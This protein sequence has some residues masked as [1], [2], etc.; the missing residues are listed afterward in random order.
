M[1]SW[2]LKGDS[3]SF[4][5]SAPRTI[6]LRNREGTPNHVEIFDITNIPSP[7]SAISETT[8]LCDIFGDDRDSP[9][10][11]GSPAS[12]AFAPPPREVDRAAAASPLV[13]DSSGS[14]H[15]A[16][17]SSEGEE[18]FE[19]PKERLRSPLL[20]TGNS[21][22]QDS[23]GHNQTSEHSGLSE[24][25]PKLESA[26]SPPLPLLS[27]EGASLEVLNRVP[28]S[29]TPSPRPNSSET[30]EGTEYRGITSSP[31]S[32]LSSNRTSSP[33][34]SPQPSNL[35]ASSSSIESQ[36]TPSLLES[37]GSPKRSSS[38]SGSRKSSPSSE[39]RP[40]SSD[41]LR[42]LTPPTFNP[43]VVFSSNST[44]RSSVDIHRQSGER[45][46]TPESRDYSYSPDTQDCSPFSEL[47]GR[48][49]V[50]DLFSRG[51]T[52]DIDDSPCTSTPDI[53]GSPCTP[54]LISCT[55]LAGGDTPENRGS[56]LSAEAKSAAS[57][58]LPRYTPPSPVS[59]IPRTPE[60]RG[61][62][63]SPAVRFTPSPALSLGVPH[64]APTPDSLSLAHSPVPYSPP[65][66]K[67]NSDCCPKESD[68]TSS[69]PEIRVT[70]SSPE[71]R[72]REKSLEE[73]LA[74]NSAD[75]SQ[76]SR[77]TT[78]S[79]HITGPC[80]SVVQPEDG[81][82]ATY[83]EIAHLSTSEPICRNPQSPEPQCKSPVRQID[84][85]TAQ[86]ETTVTIVT[87][88]QYYKYSDPEPDNTD[89]TEL[90]QPR[91][92]SLSPEPRSYTPSPELRNQGPSTETSP[93]SPIPE[94]R[95]LFPVPEKR[96]DTLPPE[97]RFLAPSPGKI[98]YT[99]SPEPIHFETQPSPSPESRSQ[100]VELYN[101]SPKPSDILPSP[102]RR[103]LAPSPQQRNLRLSSE[104]IQIPPSPKPR[105]L[106][107][108]PEKRQKT[109][110]PQ[111]RNLAPSP[112][113]RH[114]TPSPQQRDLTSST[115]KR[116]LTPSPQLRDPTQSPEKSLFN[117]SPQ[118]RYPTPSPVNIHYTSSPEPINFAPSPLDIHYSPMCE[119]KDNVFSPKEKGQTQSP[120]LIHNPSSPV[121][122]L[123]VPSP[124]PTFRNLSPERRY[125]SISP[126]SRRHITLPDPPRPT[127][128]PESR[129]NQSL[130]DISYQN[131]S[132]D[133]RYHTPSPRDL[134]S[135]HKSSLPSPVPGAE[136]L[137]PSPQPSHISHPP[138]SRHQSP[139][140]TDSNALSKSPEYSIGQPSPTGSPLHNVDPFSTPELSLFP[141]DTPEMGESSL[142]DISN[143][144]Q[145][146]VDR[147]SAP[148]ETN[149][150]V[151]PPGERK[152]SRTP[153]QHCEP[154]E[155]TPE[156]T[157]P[158]S[159]QSNYFNQK[160]DHHWNPPIE[161]QSP[162]HGLPVSTVDGQPDT[163]L[164]R[165]TA[166]ISPVRQGKHPKPKFPINSRRSDRN[167][168]NKNSETSRTPDYPRKQPTTKVVILSREEPAEDTARH[169]SKRRTPSP[170]ITRFTPVHIIAPEKPY[171]LW[172]N[173]CRSPPQAAASTLT[174]NSKN[175]MAKWGSPGETCRNSNNQDDWLGQN[176]HMG[177]VGEISLEAERKRG[178]DPG[179]EQHKCTRKEM[180]SERKREERLQE[181][182]EGTKA[183][184]SYRGQQ[185]ELSFSARNRK[186]PE[187][188]SAASTGKQTSKGMPTAHSYS[189]R[190][191]ATRQPQQQQRRGGPARRLQPSVAQNMN[192]ATG[193]VSKNRPRQSS[194]SSIGSEQDEA[195]SEVK[196][197][198]DGAFHSLSSP[199]ID[200]LD[201]YNSSH[202]SSTNISQPSTQESPAGASASLL[203]YADFR[204]S[205]Q[206]LD[207]EDFPFQPTTYYSDGLDPAK[208]Y[209]MGSFECVDVAV[210]RE[211]PRKARRGVPKR[212]IQLKRKN[213]LESRQDESSE[214]GSPVVPGM[215]DS[216]SFRGSLKETLLR[217]HSTPVTMHEPY[218]C[219]LSTDIQEY[220]NKTFKLQKSTSLDETHPK[221]K[222]ATCLIKSVLSKKMQGV[223]SS[224]EEKTSSSVQV[225]DTLEKS[226]EKDTLNLS[227]SLKSQCSLLSAD[228]A[229]GTESNTMASDQHFAGKRSSPN[230]RTGM[231]SELMVPFRRQADGCEREEERAASKSASTTVGNKGVHFATGS[232]S[233][234]EARQEQEYRIPSPEITDGL[235]KK[236]SSLNVS[237]TPELDI[238]PDL[239]CE[240]P[241]P[242]SSPK[243]SF[244]ENEE[245]GESP[246][247]MKTEEGDVNGNNK[248]K[249]P[250]HKVRDVRRLVKNTYNLSF[251]ASSATTPSPKMEENVENEEIY[252]DRRE[253]ITEERKVSKH[254]ILEAGREDRRKE[255]TQVSK[256]VMTDKQRRELRG[257]RLEEPKVEGRDAE[258]PTSSATPPE[259]KGRSRYHSQPMQIECKAVCLKEDKEKKTPSRMEEGKRGEQRQAPAQLSVAEATKP[260]GY[261][262]GGPESHMTDQTTT[263]KPR[264]SDA[265][266]E[267]KEDSLEARN[268]TTPVEAKPETARRYKKP[269]L[270]GSLPKLPS[271]EREV[272]T[273]V[274]VIRDGFSKHK[275][276]Q[277]ERPMEATASNSESSGHAVSML[278][279]EKGYQ[280]EIG[281]VLNEGEPNTVGGKGMPHKHV[282]RLEIPL[283]ICSTSEGGVSESRRERTFS[284]SST[285]SIPTTET[286]PLMGVEE[287][288]RD[289]AQQNIE[290]P[291][292]NTG[293]QTVTPPIKDLDSL[294]RQDPIFPPRSPALRYKPQQ[295]E[296]KSLSKEQNTSTNKKSQSIEVKS[297][298]N[299]QI[300][301][302][303]PPKP[304]Y[305]FKPPDSGPLPNDSQ[306][307]AE[308]SQTIVVSSPTI[309]RKLSSDSTP[310]SNY[311]RKLAVSAVS[312]C[313]PPQNKTTTT[314]SSQS[315]SSALSD[316]DQPNNRA[317]HPRASP[318]STSDAQS[319]TAFAPA[320][321]SAT[322][323]VTN[324]DPGLIHGPNV[325]QISGS[326][327]TVA[328]GS[329]QSAVVDLNSQPQFS[330]STLAHD[331]VRTVT[332]N[333]EK[334]PTVVSTTRVPQY[335]H[336]QR[337]FQRSLSSEQSQ[338]ADD[339][340]FYCSDDPP[341]YDE[342]ESFSPLLLQGLTP[343]KPN[344]YFAAPRPPPC[345]CT[346]G[347]PSHTGLTPPHRHHSPHNHTPPASAHSP[348]HPHPYPIA[349]PPLR[350]HQCRA[351]PPPMC[352]QPGSPKS[353]PLGPGPPPTMYHPLNQPPS[354][355]PHPSLMQPCAPERPLQPHQ[356]MEPRRPSLQRSS[357]QQQ[358][359]QPGMSVAPYGDHGHGH[360]PG[361]AH[362]DS[363]Y[364]CGPQGMGPSYGSEYEGDGS[365][366]YSEGSFGQTP[367]R[368]LMDPETGKYF[369][370]EVP[371]QPLRKML[372]D[373]ETGQ[374]VEVL[375][376]Q[377]SMSHSGMYP[378][379]AA[380]YPSLH[381]PNMYAP[382]PQ[383]MQPY[384]APPPPHPQTQPPPPPR[385][386][387][388]SAA[389]AL[390]PNGA[391]VVYGGPP[392]QGSK[393]DPQTHQPLDQG[394]LEGMYYVPTGMNASPNPPP[395]DFY[396]KHSPGPH[397]GAGGKRS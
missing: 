395:P 292:R 306:T 77:A 319:S 19:D 134:V 353:S 78:C 265:N 115:E 160:E 263:S 200:Y 112:E 295:I 334:Q 191:P 264:E 244:K 245:K 303:V 371:V 304:N 29:R 358:Q 239:H 64:T 287:S 65:S 216:P 299:N 393:M 172:Q 229:A 147:K 99:R 37:R 97:P 145:R 161:M 238:K 174:D 246:I 194:S 111:P 270:L 193:R 206:R 374:Y 142:S 382:A 242:E 241:S 118:P 209:E 364:M 327:S 373:P 148:L 74:L 302:A 248:V 267:P 101:N 195:D 114:L 262:C 383:Y 86:E 281:A 313:R 261:L 331:Q 175:Q 17:G 381:N 67:G 128:S 15:T 52:P 243:P 42:G 182:K 397:S 58:P 116:Q 344:R 269:P 199:E 72:R 213:T 225:E 62:S 131:L 152:S 273:A 271:K 310:A 60:C 73:D 394:Y 183:H 293:R 93:Y 232:N 48:V 220:N 95:N 88:D 109:P 16:N 119:P 305:K 70:A 108:S 25:I 343:K 126:A 121:S 340:R 28:T 290:T 35:R 324:S 282:N 123:L 96:E 279:K 250:M 75:P 59:S 336:E 45:S 203:A 122:S 223:D 18:G 54:E 53:D 249:V 80:Y 252:Q 120:G 124:E 92:R 133:T 258:H 221:T 27:T 388:S 360:S 130:P 6:S 102:E 81:D 153:E 301:P 275:T 314:V 230:E 198:T 329:G 33:S 34:R 158:Q 188:H 361:L 260:E 351:E 57:T 163:L 84:P 254:G 44:S 234:M 231:R 266:K 214:N 90:P 165:Q 197:F 384:A 377:Q 285:K 341:S 143:Y 284:T 338:R 333:Y 171:R 276:V 154:S 337:P 202:R 190:L 136:Q 289:S 141:Q 14:Y 205:G 83:T 332:S 385:L 389:T 325:S 3:Y 117:P 247:D 251:K 322:N 110:S 396:H 181:K 149:S 308:R 173:R 20:P 330:R 378:P 91:D 46:T 151:K 296:V 26:A 79:P 326:S 176:R 380:P 22:G 82:T 379:T 104:K 184:A 137:T 218:P 12:G 386:P 224:H 217:Q 294:K 355:P 106:T 76:C 187:S 222:M 103:Q 40:Q 41:H 179:R 85:T 166:G 157:Y 348:G 192:V 283:Q 170:P 66:Y 113:K 87:P 107:P 280:A 307:P 55:S 278:L 311:T 363:Q 391:G 159:V 186:G 24:E 155:I 335:S 51:S 38:S 56:K 1:D 10:L 36:L 39:Q 150:V 156:K 392:G 125:Q 63:V 71:V 168:E 177:I 237:L 43:R 129:I 350:P 228:P 94:Q 357:Q 349:P 352:Y 69:S 297:I 9:S 167:I 208:R 286:P 2:T 236:K 140:I 164:A 256:K 210:E 315:N 21:E 189:E 376:P 127:V 316:K 356:H 298:S 196:W 146:A 162:F 257:D 323:P 132:P 390:H 13:D 30:L 144:S 368:M 31:S 362:L 5:R 50:H 346:S 180:E 328:S 185:V 309:Y 375:I 8:C 32:S 387:D 11:S 320:S 105:D 268:N 100:K 219:E 211:E 339:L 312:S 366:M 61:P 345:S 212:Q 215:A 207:N 169:G 4:L 288:V 370:I 342:R 235:D 318:Q 138:S 365:S 139:Q 135:S 317:H 233:H 49:S 274:V 255:I 23:E 7:R 272:S 259:Q 226:T 178:T 369:Y 372:F 201:M 68:Y 98:H 300:K 277:D 240:V 227:S 204:G 47:R 291:L 359:Q 354:Y 89:T 321:V 367:R 347:C 253:E